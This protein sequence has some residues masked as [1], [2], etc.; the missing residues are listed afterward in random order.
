MTRSWKS[1]AISARGRLYC[2]MARSAERKDW[3]RREPPCDSQREMSEPTKEEGER[4]VTWGVGGREGV[5]MTEWPFELV[6]VRRGRWKTWP[7]IGG[8]GGGDVW[9]RG[10]PQIVS[11]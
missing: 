10:I 11:P 5:R 7:F 6:C 8:V 4:R 3:V 2:S 1:V 9:G